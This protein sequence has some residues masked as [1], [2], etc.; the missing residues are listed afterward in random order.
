LENILSLLAKT[1]QD[2]SD[3][4][5]VFDAGDDFDGSTAETANFKVDIEHSLEALLPRAWA[6]DIAN[7]APGTRFCL[8]AA[9]PLVMH[10]PDSQP[11][12]VNTGALQ[13]FLSLLENAN[14][15]CSWNRRVWNQT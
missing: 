11:T 5:L 1:S 6:Q 3:D 10:S 12:T 2:L 14:V 7:S 15:C 9:D 4:Y 8:M 13:I